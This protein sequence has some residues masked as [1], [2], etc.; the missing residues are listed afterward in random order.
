[1]ISE[2]VLFAAKAFLCWDA[3]R[4][5]SVQLVPVREAAAYY[6]PPSN[7]RHSIIV[8][9]TPGKRDLSE[10]FFLLFHEAGH[11]CQ[12]NAG[13][14]AGRQQNFHEL[15]DTPSGRDKCIFEHEA[16]ERGREL[17]ERFM[18]RHGLPGTVLDAY[19]RFRDRCLQSYECDR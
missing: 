6:Y 3:L 5:L 4:D 18:H 11:A 9:Y 1:M 2:P 13:N 8:F 14:T 7:R 17:L 16:W 12:W 10:P 19:S 15:I